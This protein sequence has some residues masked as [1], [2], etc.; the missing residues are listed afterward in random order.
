MS[1]PLIRYIASLV[2]LAPVVAGSLRA[3]RAEPPAPDPFRVPDGP[4]S[5]I[6]AFME[7]TLSIKPPE[8]TPESAQKTL[9]QALAAII[10]GADKILAD[11]K[12]SASERDEAIEYKVSI[13]FQGSQFGIQGYADQLRGLAA[14]LTKKEPKHKL[15]PLASFLAIKADHEGISGLDPAALP[16]VEDFIQNFPVDESAVALLEQIGISA[17]RTGK[18]DEAAKAYRLIPKY[19]PKHDLSALVP[20]IVRRLE[21]VGKP[22]RL[23][24]SLRGSAPAAAG[25]ID[26]ASLRGKV[27]LVDFWA[28]WCG[29]CMEELV[30]LKAAY[31]KYHD[32]GFEIVGAPLDEEMESLDSFLGRANLPWPQLDPEAEGEAGSLGLARHYGITAI[33]VMILVDQEGKVVSTTL[34]GDEL[35]L[36][37]EELL[38]PKGKSAAAGV[39]EPK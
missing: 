20:G 24:G 37:L 35:E 29:P 15:A 10:A 23:K 34:R 17:E 25:T 14:E 8:E 16:E 38:G 26:L 6:L 1:Q 32:R 4:P 7:R 13:L 9:R 36:K 30:N 3:A 5:A 39:P 22:I 2:L 11:P 28:T 18:L 21:L 27:V 19:F 33:P 12:T 31:A